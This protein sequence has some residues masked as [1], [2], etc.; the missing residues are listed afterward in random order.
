MERLRHLHPDWQ[1]LAGAVSSISVSDDQIRQRI[2][3]D[4]VS[5]GEV[6]CPHTATAA[7]AY[8]HMSPARRATGPWVLVSTAH[9]AKFPETVE[10]LIGRNVPV[11][12]ALARLLE[13][14]RQV[15]E[16][17]ATLEALAS[18]LQ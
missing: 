8:A 13:L 11:P 10:P 12:P 6:W 15:T 14:P 3:T 4:D 9:P 16:V 17:P 18:V 2:R 5:L 7:E 1:E